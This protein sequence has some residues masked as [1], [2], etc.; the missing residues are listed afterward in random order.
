MKLTIPEIFKVKAFWEALSFVL[1]GLLGLAVV[2][3]K[4]PPEDALT[5][6][7]I[8]AWFL[9]V[10]KLFGVAVELRLRKEV[11]KLVLKKGKK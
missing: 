11:A 8:L 2:L 3:G 7:T 5:P 4:L 10:L 6:A 9:A 1:A